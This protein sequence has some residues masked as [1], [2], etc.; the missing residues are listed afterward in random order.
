MRKYRGKRIDNGEWVHGWLCVW[1]GITLIFDSPYN[2]Y[3][4]PVEVIPE[5]VGRQYHAKTTDNPELLE[6]DNE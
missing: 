6:Q 4:N 1:Q 2:L 5:S 3:H